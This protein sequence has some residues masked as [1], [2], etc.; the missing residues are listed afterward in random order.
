M[1]TRARTTGS[2]IFIIA[3]W[4]AAV[5]LVL[6]P[7]SVVQ[8]TGSTLGD[9]K[10]SLIL[11]LSGALAGWA[12]P[13]PRSR[14]AVRSLAGGLAASAWLVI[15]GQFW[16]VTDFPLSLTW[17]EGNHLWAASLFLSPGRY[18]LATPLLVPNYVTPG[19]YVLRGLPLV[20]PGVN[21]LWMRVWESLLW[22]WPGLLFGLALAWR[23][24]RR[25]PMAGAVVVFW[26]YLFLNQG[27]VY[28]PLLLAGAIT[29]W[30]M[31]RAHQP[32]RLLSIFIATLIAGL[33]RWTWSPA[34][35][36]WAIL[37][38]ALEL[39]TKDD[40]RSQR[41]PLAAMLK[42][43][44][45]G[46]LAAALSQ[47]ISAWITGRPAMM[48]LNAMEHPLLWYRLAPNATYVAGVVGAAILATRPALALVLWLTNSLKTKL[49]TA[50]TRMVGAVL[51]IFLAGGLVVSVKIGG[52]NNLHNLDVFLAT[53]ALVT[54][55]FGYLARFHEGV[56]DR[57]TGA[58]VMWAAIAPAVW[59]A[60]AYQPLP[61]WPVK[62]AESIVSEINAWLEE[63]TGEGEIL[64]I[65]QRQLLTMG[66][67]PSVPLV[68]EYELVE[69]MDHAMADN[70]AYFEH[71][72]TDLEQS[73]FSLIISDPLF[74]FWK[75]RHERFG[76]ENDAWV[77]YVSQPVLEYYQP[78][79]RWDDLGVWL[80][81]PIGRS[82]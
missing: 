72:Y 16:R 26:T 45:A 64:F 41:W 6:F 42:Y 3:R 62:T 28:A 44:G 75:G 37:M 70:Q 76:E 8:W 20:I 57:L 9:L 34:P 23:Y 77:R 32:T 60:Y 79:A 82:N 21:L 80:L 17:S 56:R 78:I 30:G 66:L 53:L 40:D 27:P 31:G 65:D 73:R 22:V 36:V 46:V 4:L 35:A 19:L 50:D 5:V 49:K 47:M 67:L 74:V 55:L 10:L 15:L 13:F 18:E 33:S 1:S 29:V 11:L 81:A 39:H 63:A 43:A 38:L 51:G 59:G 14:L 12:A 2:K 24:F 54:V 48:Y 61:E 68:S 25:Y 52:G 71:F 7:G 58:L 69:M